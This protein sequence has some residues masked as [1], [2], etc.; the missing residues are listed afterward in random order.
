MHMYHFHRYT[1][2]ALSAAYGTIYTCPMGRLQRWCMYLVVCDAILV[3]IIL[4][5]IFTVYPLISTVSLFSSD[6][7]MTI[8]V[9]RSAKLVVKK[10]KVVSSEGYSLINVGTIPNLNIS[11]GYKYLG[12]LQ[13]FLFDDAK[14]KQI[15]LSEYQSQ[16]CGVLSS[17]LNG[18]YKIIA[19]NSYALLVV[20]YSAGIIK[21]MQFELDD[22]DY[23][24][25]KLLTIHKGLHSKADI[26]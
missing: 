9:T 6:I 8:N 13:D 17:H 24:S 1:H 14:V 15:V 25:R 11:D 21:W 18:H 10:G 2:T 5:I 12:I 16:F 20:R 3:I 26:H 4:I 23:R 22:I 7:G 19:L